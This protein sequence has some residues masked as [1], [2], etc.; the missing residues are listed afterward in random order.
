MF[1]INVKPE[2]EGNSQKSDRHPRYKT[3]SKKKP[4]NQFQLETNKDSKPLT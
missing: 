4:E 2:E 1:T 3:N